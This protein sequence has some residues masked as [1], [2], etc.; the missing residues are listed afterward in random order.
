M[1]EAD[2]G[3]QALDSR[4]TTKRRERSEFLDLAARA[5]DSVRSSAAWHPNLLLHFRVFR[6]FRGS[7]PPHSRLLSL[8]PARFKSGHVVKC[9]IV[10]LFLT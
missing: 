7:Y 1:E 6:V 5:F 9:P 3:G 8:G 2:H 4:V 10:G